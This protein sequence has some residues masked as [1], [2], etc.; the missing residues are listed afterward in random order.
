M[1]GVHYAYGSVTEM[2]KKET[3]EY[4][5]P[6]TVKLTY[7]GQPLI[8][9][10]FDAHGNPQIGGLAD[11]VLIWKTRQLVR[12]GVIKSQ[13]DMQV[14]Y[15]YETTTKRIRIPMRQRLPRPEI[16]PVCNQPITLTDMNGWNEVVE[17]YGNGISSHY[18]EPRVGEIESYCTVAHAKC[19]KEFYRLKMIDEITETV[20]LVFDCYDVAEENRYTWGKGENQMWYE[21]IPNEYCSRQCCAHRPWFL[22][23]TPIGDIKIGWRKRVINITFMEN[24]AQFDFYQLFAAEN[25]T[26]YDER[27]CRTIHAWGKDKMYEY[28]IAVRDVIFPKKQD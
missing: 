7:H 12:D 16:C 24:F 10:Q 19:V 21:L 1:Q 3:E 26:K 9:T 25:V 22:F 5:R 17:E 14:E 20:N 11:L 15:S 4:I 2:E 13:Y 28:L 27:G 6:E 18:S 8:P 23:H